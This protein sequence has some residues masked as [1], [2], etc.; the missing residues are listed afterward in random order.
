MTQETSQAGLQ[1]KTTNNI[2]F[3]IKFK[4]DRGKSHARSFRG[5]QV[6][7]M[8][9]I[10]RSH[11]PRP[12]LRKTVFCSLRSLSMVPRG[13]LARKVAARTRRPGFRPA[14][15]PSFPARAQDSERPHGQHSRRPEQIEAGNVRPWVRSR[16][17]RGSREE[18]LGGTFGLSCAAPSRLRPEPV[19][20]GASRTTIP[21][22]WMRCLA[23]QFVMRACRSSLQALIQCIRPFL[24]VF[25][26]SESSAQIW[27]I[28]IV[29]RSFLKLHMSVSCGWS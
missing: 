20:D 15:S 1:W 7:P 13:H 2:I 24:Q 14:R 22:G 8:G 23:R 3:T 10:F 25:I 18:R 16:M 27:L 28:P 26:F 4:Y 21:R 29:C 17:Q 9:Q 11:G 5:G 19:D 6:V 12:I